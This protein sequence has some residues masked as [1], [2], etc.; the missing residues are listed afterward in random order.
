MDEQMLQMLRGLIGPE[1]VG[2]WEIQWGVDMVGAPNDLRAEIGCQRCPGRWVFSVPNSEMLVSGSRAGH[3]ELVYRLADSYRSHVC[4]R[5][6]PWSRQVIG[7]AVSAIAAGEVGEIQ[8]D[9]TVDAL[10]AVI[11]VDLERMSAESGWHFD[12]K[13]TADGRARFWFRCPRCQR[14]ELDRLLDGVG[15]GQA[16]GDTG[17]LETL[18]RTHECPQRELHDLVAERT[19]ETPDDDAETYALAQAEAWMDRVVEL[20]G[21]KS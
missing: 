6:I 21:T 4:P 14:T 10:A 16:A 7:R 20:R 3:N 15:L 9:A 19:R 8:I 13:P 1:G 2:T 5:S 17:C 11:L 18:F 12:P